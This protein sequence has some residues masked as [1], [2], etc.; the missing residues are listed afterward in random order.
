MSGVRYELTGAED[1]LAALERAVAQAENPQGLFENIGMSLV[2]STQ[3]RFETGSAPD[4]SP[5]PPSIRAMTEGGRTLV[6][7]ARLMQSLTYEA[8]ATGVAVGTN[9]IY[10][11]VHQLGAVI[12]PVNA[13]AL[14]FRIGDRFITAQ[15]V[16]IP[17]RS[18]LG[19]DED[20]EAEIGALAADWLLGPQG[21][22]A[23]AAT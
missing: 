8:F 14:F 13:R 19:L 22:D 12:R 7:S 18:F 11:A 1:A 16:R 6:A 21:L 20:D 9:V 3:R 5:W 23:E 2:T 15:E 4:G 17:A 10:A